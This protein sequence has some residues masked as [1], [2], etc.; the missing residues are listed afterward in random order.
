LSIK[1]LRNFFFV[2]VTDKKSRIRKDP[3][4]CHGSGTLFRTLSFLAREFNVFEGRTINTTLKHAEVTALTTYTRGLKMAYRVEGWCV[5][6]LV[7]VGVVRVDRVRHVSRDQVGV[8]ANSR[9]S[10][11]AFGSFH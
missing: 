10:Y 11:F 6:L 3:T 8:P 9:R 5:V 4:K 7:L 1:T 2:G